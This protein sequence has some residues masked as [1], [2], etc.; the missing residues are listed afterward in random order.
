MSNIEEQ[1]VHL[2]DGRYVYVTGPN[3][4][5]NDS[6]Q[7]RIKSIQKFHDSVPA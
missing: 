6:G 2:Y 3:M 7:G 4:P 1:T 5:G